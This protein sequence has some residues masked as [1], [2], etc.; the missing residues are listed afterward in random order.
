MR[1]LAAAALLLLPSCGYHVAGRADQIPKEVR[2]IAVL[3]F[4]NTTSRYKLDQHL[5]RALTHEFLSRTRFRV[6]PEEEDADATLRG[7][8][9]N[10][11]VTPIIF[12]PASGRAT[13]IQVIAQL[14]VTLTERRTGRVLYQN[15][16]YEA[17]ERYEV[18]IDPRAYFDESEIAMDRLSQ[19]VARSLVS[20]VLERF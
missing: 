4:F 10:I 15:Q 16:N 3:P 1:L 9:T 8:V 11:F 19:S 13:S 2:T 17:R 18:A 20:A 14:Q 5:T 12:D 7:G 6:V